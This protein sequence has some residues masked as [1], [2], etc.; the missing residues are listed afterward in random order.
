MAHGRCRSQGSHP[1]EG[2]SELRPEGREAARPGKNKGRNLG[3]GNRRYKGSEAGRNSKEATE[4]GPRRE[5]SHRGGQDPGHE[6][7]HWPAGKSWGFI[8][9]LIR[10]FFLAVPKSHRRVRE[11]KHPNKNTTHYQA[12]VGNLRADTTDSQ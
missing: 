12:A 3:R 10:T 1:V 7:S 9:I 6:G 2:I 8:L 4:S 11:C 5:V